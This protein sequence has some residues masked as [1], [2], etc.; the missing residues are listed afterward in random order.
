MIALFL[1]DS[2]QVTA[3]ANLYSAVV[4]TGHEWGIQWVEIQSRVIGDAEGLTYEKR[5]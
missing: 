4:T 1:Y 3:G 2:G 5:F